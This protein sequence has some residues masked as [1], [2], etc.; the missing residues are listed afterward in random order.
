MGT[1]SSRSSKLYSK[2]GGWK[3]VT[4][5]LVSLTAMQSIPAR[6]TTRGDEGLEC[7]RIESLWGTGRGSVRDWRREVAVRT[8]LV[9]ME[10]KMKDELGLRKHWF[11]FL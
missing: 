7:A 1:G 10:F 3:V 11:Q 5:S 6:H 8:G 9:R 2:A 4:P